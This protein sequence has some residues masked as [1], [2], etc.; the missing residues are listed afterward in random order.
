MVAKKV[1]TS[2]PKRVFVVQVDYI[3]LW[4]LLRPILKICLFAVLSK[5][6]R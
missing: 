1:F 6:C 2:W 3:E 5:I 4:Y